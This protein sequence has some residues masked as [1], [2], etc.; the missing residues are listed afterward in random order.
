[1][2]EEDEE[3]AGPAVELGEG[4]SVEGVPLAQV[5][6]RLH[7]GIA[8]SEVDRREGDTVLRTPEGSRTLS[9]VLAATDETYFP[10]RPDFVAAV[11]EE[12][13]TGPVPTE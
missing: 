7:F 5:T 1:M 4:E 8:A 6:A 11:R 3:D 12:V 13:G 9:D 10:S 2:S